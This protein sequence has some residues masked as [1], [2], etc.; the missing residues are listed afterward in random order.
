MVA[1][2][3]EA[4]PTAAWIRELSLIRGQLRWLIGLRRHTALGP[5][6]QAEYE[7]LTRREKELLGRDW[8]GKDSAGRSA[9]SAPDALG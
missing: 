6:N 3:D 9:S 7:R 8:P 5:V 4:D 2:W 1:L